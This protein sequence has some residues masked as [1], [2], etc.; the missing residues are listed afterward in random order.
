VLFLAYVYGASS[1]ALRRT[2]SAESHPPIVPTDSP[3]ITEGARLARTRGCYGSCHGD[4]DGQV[5]DEPLLAVGAIP[6]LTRLV[7]QYDDAQLELVIRH[8]IKPD[9]RSV[10]EFMPSE[11]FSYLSDDD[12]GAIIAFL[13]SLPPANGPGSGLHFRPLGRTMIAIGKIGLA[14]EHMREPVTHPAPNRADPVAFGRYL[15]L[16][17]CTE[18]HGPELGGGTTMVKGPDLRIV[19]AYSLEQFRRLMRE[20]VPLG[21]RELGMMKSASTDRFAYLTDEEIGALH[22]Y[23]LARASNSAATGEGS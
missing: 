5:I 10:I 19:A 7:R 6:D 13:R 1:L 17:S 9:G 3:A 2:Y 4:A 8:G 18:C 15:A 20:G 22:A 23:L 21:G 12:L 11:M 16:S 14:A